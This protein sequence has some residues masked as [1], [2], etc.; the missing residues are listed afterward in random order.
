ML[1]Y[2]CLRDLPALEVTNNSPSGKAFSRTR[3]AGADQRAPACS[4]NARSCL[5]RAVETAASRSGRR[6]ARAGPPPG[7][8]ARQGLVGDR[9]PRDRVALGDAGLVSMQ[10]E[11]DTHSSGSSKRQ[12]LHRPRVTVIVLGWPP[13]LRE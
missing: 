9:R 5:N 2:V 7:Q 8:A 12:Q 1:A 4:V 11:A 6:E 10:K 3:R 13:E